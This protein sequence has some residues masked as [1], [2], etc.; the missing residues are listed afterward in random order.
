MIMR[1]LSVYLFLCLSISLLSQPSVQIEDCLDC[2]CLLEQAKEKVKAEQYDQAIRLYNAAKVCD[3]SQAKKVDDQIIE[4]FN[5]IR[6]QKVEADQ[7]KEEAEQQRNIARAAEGRAKQEKRK[8]QEA[9]MRAEAAQE[10]AE[11]SSR[12]KVVAHCITVLHSF[13]SH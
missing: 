1:S 9:Q 5:R 12:I 7:A 6:A 13:R 4:I 2:P 3:P 11:R 10:Q 8:A